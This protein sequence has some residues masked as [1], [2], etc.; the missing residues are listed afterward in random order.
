MPWPIEVPVFDESMIAHGSFCSPTDPDCCC[1]YRWLNRLFVSHS[2]EWRTVIRKLGSLLADDP[3]LYD[4]DETGEMS[5]LILWHESSSK[6]RIVSV[7]NSLME[8][9]GYDTDA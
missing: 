8:R 9:L 4:M 5:A 1:T 7:L 2:P 3:K 6:R